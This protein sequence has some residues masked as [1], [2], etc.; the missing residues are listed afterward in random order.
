MPKRLKKFCAEPIWRLKQD[1]LLSKNKYMF[2]YFNI[3][4]FAYIED[5]IAEEL[6]VVKQVGDAVDG[7]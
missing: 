1:D 3:R 2:E 5:S 6:R 7:G 4:L